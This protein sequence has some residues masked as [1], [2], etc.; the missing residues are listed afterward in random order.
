MV[1]RMIVVRRSFTIAIPDMPKIP[2]AGFSTEEWAM[3]PDLMKILRPLE[4][5]TRALC[6]EKYATASMVIPTI[7][8]NIEF[9]TNYTVASKDVL[10]FRA[11]L[12][13]KLH[14]R[15]QYIETDE[16]LSVATILDPR[17]R[18]CGTFHFF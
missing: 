5:A 6:G 11:V 9:L 12:V 1:E 8:A 16:V 18:E 7:G 3:M 15:F 4:A 10:L 17:F 2:I 13:Q 14:T